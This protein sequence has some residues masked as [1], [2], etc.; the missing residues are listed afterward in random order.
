MRSGAEE[1]MLSLCIPHSHLQEVF[2]D[3]DLAGV[4]VQPKSTLFCLTGNTL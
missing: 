4:K 1:V 2:W 3:A